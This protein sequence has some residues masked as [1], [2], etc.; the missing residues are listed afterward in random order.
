MIMDDQMTNPRRY[1][2]KS[3]K[4]N[5]LIKHN[6]INEK[7]T[8]KHLINQHLNTINKKVISSQIDDEI[9]ISKPTTSKKSMTYAYHCVLNDIPLF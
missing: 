2:L 6:I 3:I 8:H 7:K 1:R 9:D 4:I 5:K